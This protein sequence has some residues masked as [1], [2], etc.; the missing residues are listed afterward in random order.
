MRKFAFGLIALASVI[1]GFGMVAEAQ[2]ETA[3]GT[4]TVTPT[5]TAPGGTVTVVMSG[6]TPGETVTFVLGSTTTSATCDGEG[7]ATVSL[8]APGGAGTYA[9]TA[10]GVTSDVTAAFSV[11]VAA[12]A[13]PP[14][15]LPATGSGGISATVGIAIGLL[16]VGVA[17]FFVTQIRRRHSAIA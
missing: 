16:L 6:C 10:T 7:T 1:F 3:S 17:L 9:G 15:G 5:S 2:Y 4:A 12:A 11:V 14:G 8:P 13:I